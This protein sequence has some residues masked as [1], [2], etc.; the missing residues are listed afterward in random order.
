MEDLNELDIVDESDVWQDS[1]LV[2]NLTVDE[3]LREIY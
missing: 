3:L 1:D 2:D